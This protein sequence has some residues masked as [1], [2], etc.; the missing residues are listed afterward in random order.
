MNKND[1]G[2]FARGLSFVGKI[3]FLSLFSIYLAAGIAI[4]AATTECVPAGVALP[5]PQGIVMEVTGDVKATIGKGATCA[6][7]K[8]Q[9]V[10]TDTVITTGAKSTVVLRFADGQGVSLQRT[11]LF[12]FSNTFSTRRM[13]RRAISCLICSRVARGLLPA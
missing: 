5:N 3:L 13:P 6:V 1:I 10:V 11:R 7:S 9:T 12:M 8:G 2:M 4:A